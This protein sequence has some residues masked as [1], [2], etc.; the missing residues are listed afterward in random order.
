MRVGFDLDGVCYDFAM[1]LRDYLEAVGISSDY[2][3]IEGEPDKWHFY[4]DWGMTDE[5]FVN[6]CH[7]GVDLGI[8]FG[9]GKPRENSFKAMCE[10]RKMGHTVHIVTD[11]SFGSNPDNSVMNTLM[12]LMAWGFEYDTIDFSADKT[13]IPTDIFIEDKL[14]NYDALTTAGVETY[15][16]DRPWNQD[17][18]DNRNRIQS[19][20]DYVE[21]IKNKGV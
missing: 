1:S 9:S 12:W 14:E 2:S 4:R 19:V 8:I 13:C 7:T 16:V 6:H 3:V 21:I 17:P 15:L 20:W 10:I 11:R 18:G 5:E